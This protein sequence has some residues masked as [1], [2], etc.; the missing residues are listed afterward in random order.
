MEQG[1]LQGWTEKTK[2]DKRGSMWEWKER[3]QNT[4]KDI[5]VLGGLTDR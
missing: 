4:R 5:A 2:T 3:I 1:N